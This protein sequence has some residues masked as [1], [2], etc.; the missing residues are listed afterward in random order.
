MIENLNAIDQNIL[1]AINGIHSHYLD[2][3]MWLM[4]GVWAYL[5]VA[6]GFLYLSYRQG[7]KQMLLIMLALALT[8]ALADQLSSGIIKPLVQRLRPTHDAEIGSLIHLVKGYRG[9]L[10][11]FVSSHAAN[12]FGAAV[13]VA[14][15]FRSREVAIA[16]IVWA[17][18][19]SYSRMYMG[20]HYPG[21]IVCGAIIGVFSA[22]IFY[23]L[24][25]MASKKWALC[26]KFSTQDSK[27]MTA[28]IIANVCVLLI[29]ASL[30][31]I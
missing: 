6:L 28:A 4:S 8:I 15:L 25:T 7:W 2:S 9:G 16:M 11:G 27:F 12:S 5:V 18:A 1:L 13:L 14:L 21:D 29:V 17:V 31:E 26:T 24:F 30:F 3:F 23:R 10:Y 22:Y 20:V 19:V